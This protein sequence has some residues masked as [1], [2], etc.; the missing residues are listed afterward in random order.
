MKLFDFQKTGVKYLIENPRAFLLDEVGLGKTVQCIMACQVM[1][2]KKILVVCPAC[3]RINWEKEFSNWCIEDYFNGLELKV[4]SYAFCQN[5]K[6][7]DSLGAVEWDAVIADESQNLKSWAAVQTKNFAF[8]VINKAK[9]VWLL[10][11]TP[12]TKSAADYHPQLSILEPGKWGKFK[13]F[14]EKFCERKPNK[15]NPRGFDY[16]GFKQADVLALQLVRVGL[17]RS[18]KQVEL[19]LPSRIYGNIFVKPDPKI[20]SECLSADYGLIEQCILQGIPI[21]AELSRLRQVIGVSKV[22]DLIEWLDQIEKPVVVFGWHQSVV[23]NLY[24]NL[25]ELRVPCRV[26]TGATTQKD[27]ELYISEFQNGSIDRIILGMGASGVGINLP[28]ADTCV[29]LELPWSPALYEQAIGRADRITSKHKTI[30]IYDMLSLGTID[31]HVKNVL[32]RKA[33]GM[34]AVLN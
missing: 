7:A 18:K 11:A 30:N 24:D 17:R 21:P 8:S 3:V 31:E 14:C 27:R 34:E 1:G 32:N 28:R 15:F 29:F 26:I 20:I 23:H 2:L 25:K 22:P 6:K 4:V 33:K 10:S 13:D 19:Q 16:V 9:R 12:A 5:K